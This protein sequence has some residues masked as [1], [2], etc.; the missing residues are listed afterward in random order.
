M[1]HSCP[2][3]PQNHQIEKKANL[4]LVLSTMRLKIR[5]FLKE[6]KNEK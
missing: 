3:E 2:Q 1:F 5:T 6:I 4:F